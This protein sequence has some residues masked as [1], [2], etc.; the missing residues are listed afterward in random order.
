MK[1]FPNKYKSLVELIEHSKEKEDLGLKTP[2]A[3]NVINPAWGY[4]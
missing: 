4:T 3:K 2:C 1:G